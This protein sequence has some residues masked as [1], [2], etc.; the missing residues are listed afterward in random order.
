VSVTDYH[1][2]AICKYCGERISESDDNAGY[3]SMRNDEQMHKRCAELWDAEQPKP[4]QETLPEKKCIDCGQPV[5]GAGY[6]C[7]WCFM[8]VKL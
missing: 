7:K 5:L 1:S 4:V 6:L 8:A 3:Y 2:P